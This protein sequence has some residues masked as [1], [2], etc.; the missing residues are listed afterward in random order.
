MILHRAIPLSSPREADILAALA[1]Q[2]GTVLRWALT[3]LEPPLLDV[4]LLQ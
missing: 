3:Q 1:A 2:E 4:I